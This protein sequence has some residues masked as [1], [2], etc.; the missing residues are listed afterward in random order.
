MS[1]SSFRAV[2]A[3]LQFAP[4]IHSQREE[5]PGSTCGRVTCV[6]VCVLS[7]SFLTD[8]ATKQN[9]TYNHVGEDLVPSLG[10]EHAGMLAQYLPFVPPEPG[11]WIACSLIRTYLIYQLPAKAR[12]PPSLLQRTRHSPPQPPLAGP[13]TPD[14]ARTEWTRL[15]RR[16]VLAGNW[17]FRRIRRGRRQPSC[18]RLRARQRHLPAPG[19]HPV[20][21]R[22]TQRDAWHVRGRRDTR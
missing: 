11:R 5:F 1:R 14:S 2:R 13:R 21:R 12:A 18:R 10:L 6:C 15:L 20:L 3:V 7:V 8:T 19:E 4:L 9:E 16:G 17:P 22:T